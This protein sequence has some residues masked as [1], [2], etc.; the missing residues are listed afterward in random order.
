MKI[1]EDGTAVIDK[2]GQ[3]LTELNDYQLDKLINQLYPDIPTT[4]DWS[5]HATSHHGTYSLQFG[6][7]W[8]QTWLENRAKVQSELSTPPTD[9]VDCIV[10]QKVYAVGG[11]RLATLYCNKFNFFSAAQDLDMTYAALMKWFQ[12]FR[13]AKLEQGLTPEDLGLKV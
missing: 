9:D 5:R 13:T 6:D 12:R 1:N 7:E 8:N 11:V 2:N 4:R 10:Y 3:E